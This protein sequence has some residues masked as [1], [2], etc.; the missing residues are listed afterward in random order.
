MD[1]QRVALSEWLQKILR[2]NSDGGDTKLHNFDLGKI[3]QTLK[4][5]QHLDTF[6][7]RAIKVLGD[8]YSSLSTKYDG[9]T[10]TPAWSFTEI[11]HDSE[12]QILIAKGRSKNHDQPLKLWIFFTPSEMADL[13][14]NLGN[15]RAFITSMDKAQFVIQHDGDVMKVLA[16]WPHIVFTFQDSYLYG[17]NSS[18]LSH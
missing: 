18:D 15:T 8:P 7:R 11:H 1:Y 14:R 5:F 12:T 9:A 10:L 3:F 4:I 16:N 2:G 17:I 13:A 6:K